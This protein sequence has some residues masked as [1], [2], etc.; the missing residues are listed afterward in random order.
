MISKSDFSHHAEERF[1]EADVPLLDASDVGL[2]TTGDVVH[3]G[4]E[5]MEG[6]I[7]EWRK[8]A[9]KMVEEEKN[10]WLDSLVSEYRHERKKESK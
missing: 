2:K 9:R 10:R 7:L 3:V 4:L 5:E 1:H 8:I 6:A